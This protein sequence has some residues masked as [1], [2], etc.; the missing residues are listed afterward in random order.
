MKSVDEVTAGKGEDEGTRSLRS[1]SGPTCVTDANGSIP[2][3]QT[4][5]WQYRTK[6]GEWVLDVTISVMCVE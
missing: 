3:R 1:G 4:Q 6:S 5:D 2:G